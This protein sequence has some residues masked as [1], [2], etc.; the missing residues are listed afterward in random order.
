MF[1]SNRDKARKMPRTGVLLAVAA[2]FVIIFAFIW[3]AAYTKNADANKPSDGRASASGDIVQGMLDRLDWV[4]Q[5]FIPISDFSRPGT[6]LQ[7]VKGI[8]I[9]YVGN[10]GTTALQ[11]RSY[12]AGLTAAD[13]VFASSNFIIGLDGGI[14]QCVPVDEIAYASNERNIDTLSIELCHP[15]SLTGR[16][17]DETYISAV[18][19]CVWL[20]RQ[21]KLTPDDIIRHYDV[22]GKICPLYFV[23]NENMWEAFKSDVRDRLGSAG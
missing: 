11:N 2:L 7:E 13:G 12:F 16:F 17:N 5:N 18:R 1:P 14:L 6:R 10:A 3:E 22:S 20:C 9:H 23:E 19:L 4:E 21:Y 8:V 15:E